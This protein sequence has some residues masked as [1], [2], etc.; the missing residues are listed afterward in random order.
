MRPLRL[1]VRALGAGALAALIAGTLPHGARAAT[2]TVV[3]ALDLHNLDT[4]CNA[5]D[6]FYQ[7]ATGGWE[8]SHT[9]PPGRPRWGTFNELAKRNAD[10]LHGILEADASAVTAPAGSDVQK[11][12]AFYRSCMDEE[13]IER[14]GLAPV[15]PLLDAVDAAHDVPTL[16]AAEA[17]LQRAGVD[18]GLPLAARPDPRNSS[19]QMAALY[20]GGL[21]LPD[22]DAYLDADARSQQIRAAY[23]T[24]VTTQLANLGES[25][26]AAKRDAAA[27]IALETDLA[28]ATP[29]RA[30]MRDPHKTDNPTPLAQLATLAPHVPWTTYFADYHAP[31][32]DTVNVAVPAFVQAYDAQLAAVPLA[33]WKAY[34]R[35][36]VV[37]AYATAL[38][39]RFADASFALRSGVLLGV[40][41]QLPRSE[42]CTTAEGA[43][44]R[45]VLGKAYVAKYFPPA[46]KA[47]AQAMVANIHQT[48]R[49][50][51]GTLGWM[52]PATKAAAIAKLAAITKKIGY[53]DTWQDYSTLHVADGP[54][55]ANVVAVRQW[56]AERAIARIGKP[57]DRALWGMTPP[58]VN[59]YYNPSN[60]EIV[61]PAGI[62]EPPFFNPDADEAVNYGAIG[63]VIGHETT[64]GFDDQGRKFDAEGNLRDWWTPADA[65][66]FDARAKCI[67]DEFDAFE[68]VPGTHEQGR[69]VQGE[70]IADLGGLTIA[71][72]AFEKT[73]EAKAHELVDDYTPEQRFFLA[74]AQLWAQLETPAAE[75]QLAATDP[76]P[77]G[78]YRV[79]GTLQNMPQF[80]AAFHCAA[81]AKMV[82]PNP[83]QIW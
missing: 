51:I 1:A 34:L 33:T 81:N 40:K 11:L 66:N 2:G 9:L 23:A 67:V 73:P 44:L 55:A 12:G 20:L 79:I 64:H 5:C 14:A 69:L 61:F 41:E 62:L 46:A 72:K 26:D 7:F 25:P 59:A 16:I 21:G 78:R 52:S 30:D 56:N 75:R 57:T 80:A 54:Y 17:T 29:R 42:R 53:P 19:M 3:P 10:E 68:V 6:D 77:D 4:T 27:V 24:Y 74:F 8:K 32:F 38:P 65:A 71:Y 48:L 43:S 39:K 15:K 36:H 28:K 35:Y 83:C 47:R 45:D 82:R 13:E 18:T 22:R 49:E 76:H 60:N 70:A 37:D 31:A 63:A 58:T 50:D